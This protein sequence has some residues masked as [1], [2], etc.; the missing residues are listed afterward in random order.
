MIPVK[1]A[2]PVSHLKTTLERKWWNL[3]ARVLHPLQVRLRGDGES[4]HTDDADV[5]V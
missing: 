1:V 2:Q 5:L 3:L 4:K